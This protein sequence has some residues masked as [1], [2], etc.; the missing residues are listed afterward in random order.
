MDLVQRAIEVVR[1][2]P[3]NRELK[4]YASPYYDP[5]KAKEYYERTKELK[6]RDPAL[7]STQKEVFNVSNDSINKANKQESEKAQVDQEA[8]IKAFQ[9][10]ALDVQ[11][12]F[13]D[14]IASYSTD[15]NDLPLNKIPS[16]ATP[17]QK[18]FLTKENNKIRASAK[19]KAIEDRQK[20]GEKL[21]AELQRIMSEYKSRQDAIRAKYEEAKKT[22]RDNIRTQ[23]N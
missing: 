12:K 21:R 5:V 13:A 8:R 23:V 18:A 19:K 16:T 7:S 20:V 15:N 1:N 3:M 2:V 11:R 4:H 6:G 22:E 10:K 9:A 17:A 14:K